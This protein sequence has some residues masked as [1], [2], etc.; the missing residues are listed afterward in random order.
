MR[1]QVLRINIIV[2]LAIPLTLNAQQTFTVEQCVEYAFANN[3]LVRAYNTEQAI[4]EIDVKRVSGLY[5]PRAGVGAYLQY[6]LAN[7]KMLIEGGSPISPPSL[8]S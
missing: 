1:R 4:A 2:W 7:Q 6:Y 8:D 5:L 3:P